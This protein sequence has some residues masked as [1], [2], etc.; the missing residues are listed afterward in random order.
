MAISKSVELT[1]NFKTLVV[2]DDCYIRVDSLCGNKEFMS[3][4]VGFYT[5]D[6]TEHLQRKLFGF[7][8]ALN[9][10]N[11]IAQA[12]DHLKTLPEFVDAQDC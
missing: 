3:I 5:T 11:F 1:S 9:G 10:E 8:P 2:F 6:K 4:D 7:V 12:Y